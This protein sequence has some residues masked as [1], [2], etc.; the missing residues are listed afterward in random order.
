MVLY[1]AFLYHK[2]YQRFQNGKQEQEVT[3][4]VLRVHT[5]FAQPNVN[6]IELEQCEDAAGVKASLSQG[7]IRGLWQNA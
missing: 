3:G 2:K 4:A 1:P 7:P 5:L 6:T